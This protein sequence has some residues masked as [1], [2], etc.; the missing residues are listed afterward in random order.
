MQV[1]NN[2]ALS[3]NTQQQIYEFHSFIQNTNLPKAFQH[4]RPW[5]NL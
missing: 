4:R 2:S 3:H 5:L 1:T